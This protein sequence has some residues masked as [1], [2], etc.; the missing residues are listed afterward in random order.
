M[1]SAVLL[2]SRLTSCQGTSVRLLSVLSWGRNVEGQCG[3]ETAVLV[4]RPTPIMELQSSPVAALKAGKLSSAAVLQA[5]AQYDGE[6]WTWGCGKAG[7]L[8]QGN[9]DPAHEP[10][11]V[12]S[13]V[14]RA[15]VISIAMGENHSL[16]LDSRGGL[17]A[18]GENKE[19]QCGLGTPLEIIASQHRK[20]YYENMRPRASSSSV[21]EHSSADA[22]SSQSSNKSS[23]SVR[24]S[25]MAS[26]ASAQGTSGF[27]RGAGWK[28]RDQQLSQYLKK[29][30]NSKSRGQQQYREGLH[31]FAQQ[32]ASSQGGEARGTWGNKFGVGLGSEGESGARVVQSAL[33]WGGFDME[34]HLG[35]AGLQPG[36]HPTPLRIGRDH[37]PISNLLNNNDQV[38]ASGESSEAA[39]VLKGGGLEDQQVVACDASRYF[40]I[41]A[42]SSGQVWTFGACYNGSLGSHSSWSTSAQQVQGALVQTLSD[43]GGAVRVAAGS[44]FSLALTAQGRVV[45]WGKMAGHESP[46]SS[47]AEI[48]D[49]S[50]GMA[51]LGRVM[52]GVIEGL[53]P[54]RHIAAGQSHALLSDGEHV[55]AIGKL[56]DRSGKENISIPWTKPQEFLHL[57]AEGVHS[58]SCGGHSCAVVSGD[59]RLYMW[60]RLMEF[61]HAESLINRHS[62]SHAYGLLVPEDVRW[63]WAGFGADKPTLVEGLTGVKSVALGGWHALVAIE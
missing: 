38:D 33:G 46:E 25:L 31:A 52:A 44:T 62:A 39:E 37:H 58:I 53:P 45:V 24:P 16:F 50:S 13:L 30:M 7:K 54:I 9:S 12:E 8:G 22:S 20:A 18:C 2:N 5:G 42:T 48:S 1:L 41:V 59:G 47:M 15:S 3:V 14:G 17:W 43:E 21:V 19:G 61:H 23:S 36:Q 34:G 26:S 28:P 56:M 11:R 57:P 32:H 55:W 10:L 6:A 60:G 51:S 29:L 27:S 35:A 63:K 4:T 49:M 40:S